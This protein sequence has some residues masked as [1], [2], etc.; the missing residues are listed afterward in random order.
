MKIAVVGPGAV[1]IFYGAKL[2]LSGQET[3]FLVRSD[4]PIVRERGFELRTSGGKIPLR[5]PVARAA[6]AIG[7]SD[8]VVVALKTTANHLFTDLLPPLV[9]PHTALLTLQ[10]GLGNEE[11]LAALFPDNPVLG[12]L[13][14]VCLNRV[15]PGVVHHIA[16][17]QMIL[18][19]H[20][21]SAPFRA[22]EIASLLV[23]AGVSCEVTDN[24][25]RAHWDKLSWNIP[26]NGL[27][28]A[29][30]AG[31]QSVLEGKISGTGLIG[32]GLTTDRLLGD[33]PWA[34]LVLELMGEVIQTARGLG[35]ELPADLAEKQL[36]RTRRMGAYKPST[37][38]D[39][40]MGK[41]LELESLF[42]KPWACA[43]GA[44]VP[45]PRLAALC[46][47]LSE[48]NRPLASA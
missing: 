14:F 23:R 48:M 47:L 5:P 1:G 17:G 29:S 43:Q 13:C 24:L 42:L 31:F 4:Y 28:V 2:F 15:A 33:P 36:D 32:P 22:P 9:G 8:L 20:Q 44:G 7:L 12:G 6:E 27:G 34:G 38:L 39:Y 18:G 19:E 21:P 16:H 40:E 35:L 45:T 41:A 3:H 25:A 10:N 46:Q 30:A 37:L 11:Q 26:F